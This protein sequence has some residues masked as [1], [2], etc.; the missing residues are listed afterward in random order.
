MP[1]MSSLFWL[2]EFSSLCWNISDFYWVCSY[3]SNIS[4]PF[5]IRSCCVLPPVSSICVSF[6][7]SCMHPFFAHFS[8]Y[9]PISYKWSLLFPVCR[10][11]IMDL[12]FIFLITILLYIKMNETFSFSNS[13]VTALQIKHLEAC[14]SFKG[15]TYP[16]HPVLSAGAVC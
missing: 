1:Q 14:C 4:I 8:V 7:Y 3:F 13:K 2:L 5:I 9:S 12:H 16:F 11:C 10:K 15:S 6:C